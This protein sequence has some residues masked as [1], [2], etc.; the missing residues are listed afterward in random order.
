MVESIAPDAEVALLVS[1][2]LS[3]ATRLGTFEPSVR[4]IL[5]EAGISTKAFYRH[6]RSKDELLLMAV[7]E[8]SQRLVDYIEAKM[9][10][11]EDPLV[12]IK[13]WIECFVRRARTPRSARGTLPWTLAVGRLEILYPDQVGG[14]RAMVI[15]PLER[16]IANAVARKSAQSPSPKEDARMV[17]DYTMEAVRQHMVNDTEPKRDVER[18]LVAFTYRA[19]GIAPPE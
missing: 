12:R 19:L 4:A 14:G 8:G 15:W 10:A 7:D 17:Y 13:V 2:T 9:A 5:H 3:V 11:T 1:A 16:E 6:F 18:R